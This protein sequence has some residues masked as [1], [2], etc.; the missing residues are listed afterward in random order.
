MQLE[1][2]LVIYDCEIIKAI[3]STKE[4]RTEGIDYC[5]GW[6][7]YDN[8][9]ISVI[10]AYDAF[11]EQYRV[12]LKDNLDQFQDLI[13]DRKYLMGFNNIKFDDQLCRANGLVIEQDKSLDLLVAIWQAAGLG[14]EFRY[15]THIGFTLDA[16][17]EA[18]EIKCKT[19]SGA[20]APVDWQLGNYGNVIDYCLNDV[21]MTVDLFYASVIKKLNHPKNPSDKLEVEVIPGLTLED[22]RDN[23][24]GVAA[25]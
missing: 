22:H 11:E 4:P 6:E 18:N 16:M 2:S 20:L 24:A 1:R 3:P 17:C 13:N 15:P 14:P 10:C 9:G 5:L 12:F 21:K 7:D 25:S 23:A 19:G 8:M